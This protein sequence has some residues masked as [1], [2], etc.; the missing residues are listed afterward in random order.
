MS[1]SFG[2]Y[3]KS[4]S[5]ILDVFK[6]FPEIKEAIIFGSR[7]M[8]N[9]KHGSDIDIALKGDINQQLLAKIRGVLEDEISTPYLYDVVVFD[10]LE[11]ENTIQH[12]EKYGKLIYLQDV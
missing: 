3:E 7:A 4:F 12:I 10:Q 8:G 6:S 1:N 9:Y 5:L 11:N 2:I